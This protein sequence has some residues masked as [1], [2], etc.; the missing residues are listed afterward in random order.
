MEARFDT[1]ARL[2]DVQVCIG[3]GRAEE[4]TGGVVFGI[5]RKAEPLARLGRGG[6]VPRTSKH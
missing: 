5:V 1:V 3:D 2:K 4:E 6:Y